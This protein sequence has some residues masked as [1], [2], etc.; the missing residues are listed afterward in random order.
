MDPDEKFRS[1]G[2]PDELRLVLRSWKIQGASA[3]I[4]DRLRRTF[5]RRRSAP[6][7]SPWLALAASLTLVVGGVLYLRA[8]RSPQTSPV[9]ETTGPWASP[10]PK[11]ITH[12]VRATAS[13]GATLRAARRRPMALEV[14]VIVEPD[15]G[16]L[17]TQ[18]A[19]QLHGVRQ[20]G[21]CVTEPRIDVVTAFDPV[22]KIPQAQVTDIPHYRAEWIA[23]ESE[24][25]L[26]QRPRI[27]STFG[28]DV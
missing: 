15:Q 28:G 9:A 12:P 1:G 14:K 21:I 11:P 5:R 24:W 20:V 27:K 2:E 13:P 3:E 6:R 25:P 4:E 23:T 26:V 10:T 22:T 18:L 17:L 8:P 16:A 19:R 7:L